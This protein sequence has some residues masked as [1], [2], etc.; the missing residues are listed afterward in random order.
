MS[1]INIKKNYFEF[2][3]ALSKGDT[4]SAEEA[5]RKAFE[6][7]FV[8]YQLKLTNNEKFNLQNDE[9]LFAVVTLFD[10]M[11]GFWKEG[12]IDEGIAFAESMIDLVDS[13]KLKE[14]FKGY[15]LGMQAGLSVDEFLKEYVDL[16]KIDAEFPQFLCNFKE[17]IKE[18]ID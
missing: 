7:A 8:L 12:L 17:K 9:E 11:I 3:N 15:S 13:P 5:F 6:D 2:K 14:M 1:E 10:N 16:S 4:K 18:L